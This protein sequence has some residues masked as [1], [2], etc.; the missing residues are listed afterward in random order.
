VLLPMALVAFPL[1]GVLWSSIM[2]RIVERTYQQHL[3][4]NVQPAPHAE[5]AGPRLGRRIPASAEPG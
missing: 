4:D 2:W 1:G 5:P 3:R